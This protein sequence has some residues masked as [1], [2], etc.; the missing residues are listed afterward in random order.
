M[1]RRPASAVSVVTPA[2]LIP[3]G[4]IRPNHDRSQSQFSAK[5]CMVVPRATRAPIAP[6]LRSGPL[7]VTQAPLRPSIRCAVTPN[8]AHVE[9]MASSRART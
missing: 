3:Q 2:S 7:P 1:I 9:I 4:T 5:P 8:S 6:T